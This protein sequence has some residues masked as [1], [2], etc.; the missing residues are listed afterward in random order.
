SSIEEGHELQALRKSTRCIAGQRWV[1]DGVDFEVLHP[2]ASDYDSASKS[3]AMSCVLRVSNGS[4]T[5]LLAGDIE[6]PQERRL[7]AANASGLKADFLLVPHHGSKTSSSA[8]FLDAVQPP[9][10]LAQ[11]G[12]RNRFGHPVASVV[13]RY[14]ERGIRL[15]RSAQ[16]GAAGWQSLNPAQISCQR[17]TGLRYWNH[18]N[19][20]E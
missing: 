3:N 9:L 14:D 10:A 11:A 7:A 2:A 4:R 17:E 15:V 18:G 8:E 16:C 19:S 5:A 20:L 13:A 1:W 12:Y 6:A